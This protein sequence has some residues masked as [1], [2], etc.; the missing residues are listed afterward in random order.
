MKQVSRLL[1]M[2]ALLL[3]VSVRAEEEVYEDLPY[4]DR[5][6]G[7]AC[8]GVKCDP[9]MFCAADGFC[10]RINCESFYLYAPYVYTGRVP[11]RGSQNTTNQNN[12]GEED[13]TTEVGKLE[14]YIDE[15]PD[16]VEPPCQ[17]ERGLLFPVA[18][19]YSCRE[20]NTF[21]ITSSDI[22]C[23]EWDYFGWGEDG[24][25]DTR[26]RF[27]TANRVCTAKP[28]PEQRFICY[29]IAPD[30]NLTSY[31]DDYLEAVESFGECDA[32]APPDDRNITWVSNGHQ[33]TNWLDGV[34]PSGGIGAI[35]AGGILSSLLSSYDEGNLGESFDPFL[36]AASSI[37]TILMS[38]LPTTPPPSTEAEPSSPARPFWSLSGILL[39][40]SVSM[41][42]VCGGDF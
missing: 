6:F 18:V 9:G 10:H 20:D 23:D 8:A 35:K 4:Y 25:G 28:N 29:D 26:R 27:A 7:Y 19:H 39:I 31:F 34:I 33:I 24:S 42:I 17:D 12:D 37:S 16:T 5:G 32:N 13:E 15:F 21:S 3:S 36:V 14:C 11:R 1:Q 2:S 22:Q 40:L 38:D 30:T 41:L